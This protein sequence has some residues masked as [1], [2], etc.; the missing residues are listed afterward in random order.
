MGKSGAGSS[1]DCIIIGVGPAGISAAIYT[2]RAKL[3]TL[4]IGKYK[5]GALF[6]AHNVANYLGFD[7][8]I[9]GA[10]LVERA[11]KQAQNLGAE[12]IADEVVN[13]AQDKKNFVLK[14]SN[15]LLYNARSVIIA[16]GTAYKIAGAKNEQ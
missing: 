15:G 2:A 10:D 8:G 3:K 5:D 13:I 4:M 12:I 1:Y 9:K 14:T 16:S 6:K 11:V 7:N